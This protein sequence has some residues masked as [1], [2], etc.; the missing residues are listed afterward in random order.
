[1]KTGDRKRNTCRLEKIRQIGNGF[2]FQIE[3]ARETSCNTV[4]GRFRGIYQ[5]HHTGTQLLSLPLQKNIFIRRN[6]TAQIDIALYG[7]VKPQLFAGINGCLELPSIG[8]LSARFQISSL[9]RTQGHTFESRSRQQ[10]QVIH[11]DVSLI[12]VLSLCIPFVI[13]KNQFLLLGCKI[14]LRGRRCS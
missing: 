8:T 3:N 7:F 1:M 12:Q 6:V 2:F 10:T 5:H 11:C 14:G 4:I 9:C 13:V